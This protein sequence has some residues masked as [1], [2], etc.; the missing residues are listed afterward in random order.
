MGNDGIKVYD[1]ESNDL[2]T[3]LITE[4]F[5]QVGMSTA[6]FTG[7]LYVFGDNDD[8]DLGAFG[9]PL[10]KINAIY[11][12]DDSAMLLEID[13]WCNHTQIVHIHDPKFMVTRGPMDCVY[14][15]TY[16]CQT[17]EH[18]PEHSYD[19][20]DV[21]G[22][23]MMNGKEKSAMFNDICKYFNKKEEC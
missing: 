10:H 9:V 8:N 5:N 11:T 2:S 18:E 23:C 6:Y 1:K 16:F 19:D 7:H 12:K 22:F 14:H 15:C 3:Q 4:L 17:W 21:G 20:Y 13:R